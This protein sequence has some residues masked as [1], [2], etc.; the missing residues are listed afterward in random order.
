MRVWMMMK[1]K[2]G[3]RGISARRTME[4]TN[5]LWIYWLK[6]TVKLTLNI[7]FYSFRIYNFNYIIYREDEGVL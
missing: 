1:K 3:K 2:R 6:L 4:K 7:Y 5:L